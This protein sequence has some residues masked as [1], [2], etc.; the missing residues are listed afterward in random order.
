MSA[1]TSTPVHAFKHSHDYF[2]RHN[3]SHALLYANTSHVHKI[4]TDTKIYKYTH[5]VRYIDFFRVHPISEHHTHTCTC[6]VINM[7]TW[8]QRDTYT[9]MGSYKVSRKIRICLCI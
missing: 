6:K 5:L 4:H 2:I 1:I 3:Y 8:R 9:N 7:Y